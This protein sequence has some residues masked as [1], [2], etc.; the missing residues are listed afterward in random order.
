[1][2]IKDQYEVLEILGQGGDG[3]VYKVRQKGSGRIL[4]VKESR[5]RME[6]GE[7]EGREYRILKDCFHPALPV[8]LDWFAGDGYEYLVM[9]YIEGITLQEY[10]EE[11]GKLGEEQAISFAKEI[12]SILQYLHTRKEPVVYGDLK[13]SNLILTPEG[14]LRMIDF[15]SAFWEKEEKKEGGCFGSPGYASPEQ[16]AGKKTGLSADIYAFGAVFH[17]LL[18]GEDPCIP[19]YG[20]RPLRECNRALSK[21][22]EKL[23]GKCLMED[24]EKR[25]QSI[26]LVLQKLHGL[27]RQERH[28]TIKKRLLRGSY[29]LLE[30]ADGLLFLLAAQEAAGGRIFWE[31]KSFFPAMAIF[32]LL[33][34][35]RLPFKENSGEKAYL[36]EKR[37]WK[38]AGKGGLF[39][40]LLGLAAG[41]WISGLGTSEI[42]TVTSAKGREKQL[43]VTVYDAT[44]C[45]LCV[46]E[47]SSYDLQGNFRVEVEQ[48][49]FVPGEINEVT[50][51]LSSPSRDSSL[52]RQLQ[53]MTPFP[54]S[55]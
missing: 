27:K 9:E 29:L 40:L 26:E 22:L 18:T 28:Q 44:G 30:V 52:V 21:D 11:Q 39:L 31:T 38:T 15:A 5:I 34:F 14:H 4:A 53:V 7:T 33:L 24:P 19:P 55:R 13:P 17:F 43:P 6:K 50:I 35:L 25:Y 47:G 16:T 36:L 41:L 20:R 45:K 54:G 48:D 2:V 23:V 49:C 42:S 32:F 12:G 8:V 37:V 10:L 51:I 1:M 3:I 46:R